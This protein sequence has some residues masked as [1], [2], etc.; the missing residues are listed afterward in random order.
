MKWKIYNSK[1]QVIINTILSYVINNKHLFNILDVEKT[2]SELDRV[3]TFHDVCPRVESIIL[4]R[5][6]GPD[7]LNEYLSAMEKLHE[8]QNYFEKNNPQSVELE[9]VVC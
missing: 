6:N 2:L 3:I 9:N 8:A 5:P 1:K 7:G 4:G